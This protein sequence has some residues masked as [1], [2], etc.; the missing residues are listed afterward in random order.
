M[1]INRTKKTDTCNTA[2]SLLWKQMCEGE[3][4][5]REASKHQFHPEIF[6]RPQ[7]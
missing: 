1:V 4:T 7:A 5:K 3:A 6:I 2:S